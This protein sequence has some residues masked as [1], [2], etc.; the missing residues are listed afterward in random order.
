MTSAA[1]PDGAT[2]LDDDE[3]AGLR[4]THIQT[5][6][7]LN[8][9]EQ[10]NVVAG[11]DWLSRQKKPD[12]LSETFVLKLHQRLFGDV[13]RWA[14]QFRRT[15]KNVGVA[16]HQIAVQLRG[17]LD[18]ARYRIERAAYPPLELAL[19]FHHRLVQI[20]PF[21]NG[22]GR[23]ARIMTDALLKFGLHQA[24]IA[25]EGRAGIEDLKAAGVDR[26]AYVR[27]LRAADAGDYAPLLKLFG[28]E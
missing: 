19:R 15:E 22:N 2:P 4:F 20:H 28:S 3:R 1:E 6:G 11:M 7:E 16:P 12:V 8:R 5:R 17:L 9:L 21:A 23:H 24:P 14:G 10:A 18:D 13:W 26:A 25:W 27:A